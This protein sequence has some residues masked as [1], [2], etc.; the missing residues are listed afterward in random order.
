MDAACSG[1]RRREFLP[2]QRSSHQKLVSRFSRREKI[3]VG[4][5][6]S[7][8]VWSFAGFVA[9]IGTEIGADAATTAANAATTTANAVATLPTTGSIE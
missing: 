3:R 7:C 9:Q 1:F 2:S 8:T 5:T 6:R 4:V